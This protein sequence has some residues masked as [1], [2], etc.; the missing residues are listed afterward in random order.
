MGIVMS[1]D[2]YSEGTAKGLTSPFPKQATPNANSSS[3][4]Q[5]YVTML[6]L[7]PGVVDLISRTGALLE[8]SV[9]MASD[10]SYSAP[11]YAGNGYRI[12]GDAGGWQYF[13]PR[14][15]RISDMNFS[16]HRSLLLERDS[17]S[18]DFSP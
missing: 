4:T 11:S 5:S 1:Q 18:N 15:E 12:V 6:S 10:F 7:A 3:T 2:L 8:G 9:K 17:F 13:P 14:Y 16:F